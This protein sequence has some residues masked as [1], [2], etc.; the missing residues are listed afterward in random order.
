[1]PCLVVSGLWFTGHIDTISDIQMN[2]LKKKLQRKL[3]QYKLAGQRIK[4]TKEKIEVVR[5]R[6]QITTEA[7]QV[8]Q[9]VAATV[10]QETHSR[11]ASVV[12]KFLQIVFEEEAYDFEVKFEEKRGKTEAL[13]LFKRHGHEID[14]SESSGGGPQD[15]AAF[16]L[17]LACLSL[18]VPP[19][20]RVLVLDEPFIGLHKS[21]HPRV[22]AMLKVL[23]EELDFQF[24]IITHES[25]LTGGKIIE[26]E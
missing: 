15:I 2:D 23:S 7:Q 9:R 3:D 21:L 1:M 11:I 20:R 26:I 19:I 25:G 12:T 6:L 5:Q 18:T 4:S 10:Q 13:L 16:A 22:M 8:L 14:P 17:R 24:I